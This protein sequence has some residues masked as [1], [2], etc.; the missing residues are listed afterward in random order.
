MRK[1][2]HILL[3]HTCTQLPDP[4]LELDSSLCCPTDETNDFA[5]CQ[6]KQLIRRVLLLCMYQQD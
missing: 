2:E 4:T 6:G 3:L 1:I 5:P